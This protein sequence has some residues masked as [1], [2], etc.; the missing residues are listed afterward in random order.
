M[1]LE[2]LAKIFIKGIDV[3]LN[4]LKYDQNTL[5]QHGIKTS[6]REWEEFKKEYKL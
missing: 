4:T 3:L 2:L 5:D 6:Y 1:T